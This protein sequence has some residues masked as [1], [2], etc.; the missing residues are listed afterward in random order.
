[1]VV[2][3]MSMLS[4]TEDKLADDYELQAWGLELIADGNPGCGIKVG[5]LHFPEIYRRLLLIV[6]C[7][8][9]LK[10]IKFLR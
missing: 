3:F 10:K 2:V 4:D 6:Y 9:S 1:M 5:N 8:S 7:H